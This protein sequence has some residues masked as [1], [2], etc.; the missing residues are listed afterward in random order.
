[1]ENKTITI[2]GSSMPLPGD[3]EYEDAYYIGKSLAKKGYNIC[4]GGSMGIMDA[5]SKAANE[6]GR[7]AIGVTVEIFNSKTSQYLT[8]EIKC[9]T[10]YER[11]ENL[12]SIGDGYII[13]PGGTGT[14][15]E[16]SLVWEMFNKNLM[17]VKP[18]ACFGDIW[19]KIVE[20]M[21]E[22]L[23]FEKRNVNLINCFGDRESLIKF[24]KEKI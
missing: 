18:T 14:L 24:I 20:P 2:F 7:E 16:I 22:R 3:T 17:S 9:P 15:L 6:E 23:K 19:T 13:L 10:L 11:L 8:K 5:V 12:V 21:E 4:S 1:M